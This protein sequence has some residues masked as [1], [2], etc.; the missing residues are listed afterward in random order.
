MVAYFCFNVNYIC[1]SKAFNVKVMV[2]APVERS[3]CQL[4]KSIRIARKRRRESL[5]SYAKRIAGVGPATSQSKSGDPAVSIAGYA[6]ALWLTGRV[7]LHG[8]IA[9][10][11]ADEISLIRQLRTIKRDKA[12]P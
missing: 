8:E 6:T 9:N 12:A 3:L 10:P 11:E 7:H 5:V 1:M 2:L 4:G